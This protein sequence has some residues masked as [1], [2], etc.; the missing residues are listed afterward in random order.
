MRVLA[1]LLI[2]TTCLVASVA[3]AQERPIM[4]FPADGHWKQSFDS[5]LGRPGAVN[6]E[7]RAGLYV[8]SMLAEQGI[9]PSQVSVAVVVHGT[10]TFDFLTD[11]RY[12]AHYGDIANPNSAVLD[13]FIAYGGEV[14]VSGFGLEF[15]K[16]TT[17]DLLPNV[18][19]SPAGLV[20]HAE[21]ARQGYTLNPFGRATE[22]PA[23]TFTPIS[24]PFPLSQAVRVGNVLYLSGDLGIAADGSGLEPGGI[25]PETRRMMARIGETLAGHDLD[26]DDLFKCSVFL[27]D[28]DDW[29]AFNAV[30]QEFFEADRYPAR[31]AFAVS[32]L[33]ANARVE[34]ECMA[35]AK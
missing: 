1:A 9:E 4:R 35:W 8:Y 33:A 15:R 5:T 22:Q 7:L 31:S 3:S 20:A 12:R 18:G 14:W 21:L 25:E 26:Y 13:E 34:M 27:A 28:M 11:E 19:L 10:A 24:G 16:L 29:R 6:R 30:Y 32:G 2:A 17:A 23:P